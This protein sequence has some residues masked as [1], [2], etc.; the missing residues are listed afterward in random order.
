MAGVGAHDEPAA[1]RAQ[2]IA[3]GKKAGALGF[4]FDLAGDGAEVCRGDED[5]VFAHEREAHAQPRALFA[6]GRFGDLHHDFVAGAHLQGVGDAGG[7]GRFGR[8]VS[9]VEVAVFFLP[10]GDEG[11]LHAV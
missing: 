9:G 7:A 1:A 5:E 6:D 11:C 4:V 3:A 8:D 10:E 2:L